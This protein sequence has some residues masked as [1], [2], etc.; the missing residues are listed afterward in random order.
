MLSILIHW[1][2]RTYRRENLVKD[3]RCV[4]LEVREELPKI[5]GRKLRFNSSFLSSQGQNVTYAQ[6]FVI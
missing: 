3:R 4:L 1:T 2:V 6:M 5:W